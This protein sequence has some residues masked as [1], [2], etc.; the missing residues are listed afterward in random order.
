MKKTI[1]FT[2]LVLG[3]LS[4]SSCGNFSKVLTSTDATYKEA[5]ANKYFQK[6]D[7]DK[8]TQLYDDLLNLYKGTA[9]SEKLFLKLAESY[10]CEEKYL[11]AAHHFEVF[12]RTFSRS[13]RREQ[14]VYMIG[15]CYEEE[16][17]DVDLDQEFT[18]KAIKNY[19]AF[20]SEFPET[21][22][23]EEVKFRIKDLKSKLVEKD[24]QIALLYLKTENF[25]PSIRAI[26]LFLQ[27]HP[28]SPFEEKMKFSLVEAYYLLAD[29][30]VEEKKEIRYKNVTIAYQDFKH[31]FP[32]S[33]KLDKAN[34][35]HSSALAWLE[36]NKQK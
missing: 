5:M 10:Y 34:N 31:A 8:S 21:K 4:I 2:F 19:Q 13:E 29:R 27:K 20:I 24:A 32:E 28:D 18:Q 9:K 6:G 17:P 36:E 11:L 30:S 14:A 16:S 3:S 23:L 35:M 25:K 7:C 26:S 33:E 15:R 12:S 22:K 1:L